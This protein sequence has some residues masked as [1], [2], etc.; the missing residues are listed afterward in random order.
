MKVC[1]IC[2]QCVSNRGKER[3][4]RVG[5]IM[6]QQMAEQRKNNYEHRLEIER[7]SR[8]KNKEKHRPLKNAR[9][10]VRNR[11]LCGSKYA[12]LEKD[13]RRIYNGSCFRCGTKDNLSADHIVPISKGGNHSAGNLMTL[14]RSCNASKRDLF[15]IEWKYK[16]MLAQE[17]TS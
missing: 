4:K 7:R 11:I 9:Q 17:V 16:D 8:A 13:M 12:I 6:R 2:K 10:Q 14:C 1:G 5:H 15:L 3:Y